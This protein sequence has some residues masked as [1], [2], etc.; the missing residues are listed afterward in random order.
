MSNIDH[1][2]LPPSSGD[3]AESALPQPPQPPRPLDDTAK[4]VPASPPVAAAK[5]STGDEHEASDDGDKITPGLVRKIAKYVAGWNALD[6]MTRRTAACAFGLPVDA[7]DASLTVST[8]TAPASARWVLR[9]LSATK[10]STLAEGMD[11]VATLMARP[12]TDLQRC[13]RVL[14]ALEVVSGNMVTNEG[15]AAQ[16]VVMA[17]VELNDDRKQVLADALGAMAWQR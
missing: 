4:H 10:T 7:D 3:A 15:K 8:L 14:V 11:A 13:W 16:A 9:F 12:R 2:L 5:R 17:M 1:H 6:P